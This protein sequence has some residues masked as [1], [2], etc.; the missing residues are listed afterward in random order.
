MGMEA[1]MRSN[2]FSIKILSSS[3]RDPLWMKNRSPLTRLFIPNTKLTSTGSGSAICSYSGGTR[4]GP[5]FFISGGGHNDYS[6]NE[7][8]SIKLNLDVPVWWHIGLATPQELRV[9]NRPYNRDGKPA[10]R[11]TYWA[12]HW[13]EQHNRL[14]LSGGVGSFNNG[15]GEGAVSPAMD[16]FNPDTGEWDPNRYDFDSATWDMTKTPSWPDVP[17]MNSAK[18][19]VLTDKHL[20]EFSGETGHLYRC[21][22]LP[23]ME[24]TDCGM[25]ISSHVAAVPVLWDPKRNILLRPKGAYSSL[26]RIYDLNGYV[27]GMPPSVATAF[28]GPDQPNWGGCTL[29]YCDYLAS[30][31]KDAYLAVQNE[32]KLMRIWVIDPDTLN[33]TL[34]NVT[35]ED[36]SLPGHWNAN[37]RP[38]NR[39]TYVKELRGIVW[40]YAADKDILFI[41]TE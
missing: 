32:D 38:H 9:I 30:I 25:L 39:F 27:E 26:P 41:P 24:W 34:L 18:G 13:V 36:P 29:T 22:I 2:E 11:H 15:T 37:Q 6:G 10:A 4:R 19:S 16:G 28:T 33:V 17:S 1:T 8:G 20:W 35:G 21:D 14:F 5:Q 31:G 23:H 12:I 40:V 3:S 7:V